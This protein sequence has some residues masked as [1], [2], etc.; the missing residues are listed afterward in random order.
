MRLFLKLLL[1]CYFLF[2]AAF[3]VLRYAILPNVDRYKSDI[4]YTISQAIG[5]NVSIAAINV[6]WQGLNPRLA[7][8]NVVIRDQQGQNALVLPN[9]NATVS[10]WSVAVADLRFEKIE[11]VKPALDIRRDVS[12]KLY[13]AGFLIEANQDNDSKGLE[14][15]LA[16]HEILIRDGQVRWSDQLRS[17]PELLLSEVNFVLNNRWRKHN[18]A[19]KATP[20]LSLA[21]PVDIRGSFQHP[22]FTRK[23]SDISS[24]TGDLYA[25]LRQADLSGLKA[26]ISYPADLQKG[27]GTVR[28][29]IRLE[30]GRVADLTAD[31]RLVDVLGQFRKDL[32]VL[33]MAQVSGRLIASEKLTLGK[34]YLPSLFGQSGHTI[35]L[36]DFAMQ[37]RDGI[38][39]PATTI[40]ES[41]FPGEKGQPERVELY[42]KL[43]N[44]NTLANFAEHLPLPADQRQMLL[45]FAPKGQ[46][47][48]FTAQ[49]Q[50]TYPDISAYS[51]KGQFIDLSMQPQA[52]QLA[53]PKVGSTP[54][55]AAIP[56]I[57]G[58][59][60][61]SGA[62]DASDKGGK[63]SLNSSDLSL[64]LPG[65]FVDPV[66]P[67]SA[68]Q[69]Q[70][71][72][73]F[74][75][76]DSLRFQVDKMEFQQAGMKGSLT[77]KHV[78]SMRKGQEEQKGEVDISGKLSGFDVK[79]IS[80][81]IP[82]NAPEDLRHWLTTALLDGRADDVQIRIKGDLAQ[83]PFSRTD[84]K[85]VAK[86]EFL[87][88]GKIV[89]GKLDFAPG[90]LADD[91]KSPLWPVI[92]N[93]RGNFIFDR[94]KME[95][96]GDTAKTLS[97][98]LYKVK[99]EIPD[100]L[101][102]DAILNID[103]KVSA[104]LQGMLQYVTASPVDGWLGHFL[105][106]TKA[107]ANAQ[108]A[109]KLQLPLKHL[110]ESKVQGVLQ[111]ANNDAV[112]QT[113][114]P[115]ISGINGKLEFNERGVNLNAL[116]GTLLGGAV[117]A[118]G[119]TQKDGS[120][121]IKL[122]GLA[123]AEGLRNV[124][125]GT[126]VEP[127]S[128]KI[129]GAARYNAQINVAKRQP[130]LIVDS[131]L[132]GLA[133]NFPSPLQKL[134]NQNLP[135]HFAMTPVVSGDASLLRDE[136]KLALGSVINAR[137]Q[138]QKSADRNAAWQV[139]RGGI[140]VNLPAP[141][142][143]SGLHANINFQTLN[144]DEWRRLVNVR[145]G[146]TGSAAGVSPQLDFSQYIEPSSLG[147]NTAELYFLDKKLDN[148]VLGA[149]HQKGMW[150]A[151]IDS[152][153]ASG[154]ISWNESSN[155]QGLG[156]VSARLSKLIIPQSAA[157]DVSDLLEG[158]NTSSQ[159]PGLDI[160]AEN[161]ELFNKKLGSLELLASNLPAA[162][163]R[164]WRINKLLLKNEDAQLKATG[165]WLS[166]AGD[167]VTHLNYVLDIANAGKLLDRLGFANI[168][169]GGR[170]KLEGDV[171]WNGLPFAL[172]IPSMNGQLQLELAVGQFL[173]VDP[174]AAKLLGVLSMQ[175]LARRLTLDF[176]DVFS[177]G[178]AFDG[179]NAT[180]QIQQGLARTD[181]FKM[182]SLNAT[183]LIDGS[184]DIAKETQDLHVAV[185]PEI[186]A[187][188][189][190]VV[191]A[192]AVNPVIGLGTFLAQLFLREPLA[193][194]FTYEYQVTGPWKDP[195]VAKFDNKEAKNQAPK[196]ESVQVK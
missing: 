13:V 186:N 104:G 17:A 7:F 145:T 86:G 182:R 67:F 5:R 73:K 64:Q 123:T 98:D 19:L 178:F 183:V 124:F 100:L 192:L 30:K 33:D 21:A 142:P 58:F 139:V 85:S 50:G 48:E 118:T 62:I 170:G 177:D 18:F 76:Q 181:N 77:G 82:S 152:R 138:R 55:R 109:L 101:S 83:F 80:R 132:Q 120:I 44:L 126:T 180:A 11:I 37:T 27:M 196:Q 146:A 190:S 111:F 161:F 25:D 156:N 95:I 43:L 179:I 187:G 38:S 9:V 91:G 75:A 174:G 24:W 166:G 8:G 23:V 78:L 129:V 79:E 45:A 168:V 74:E 53:R 133:L 119:G 171:R 1:V 134:S 149:S 29:W 10:W 39:L 28:S 106:E 107:T 103:G 136:I 6:S 56:A 63:F 61:L 114:I 14:W 40:R 2:S 49:W 172:D 60:H 113:G 160:V 189:A 157:G 105:Q 51:V 115:L 52:A 125:S 141:E 162:I 163:G 35:S 47:K 34:K 147:V 26:Y 159:I 70:A 164:E 3:L 191:Y 108:L 66:M 57:P 94:A 54:G 143:D 194:A 137:Y 185:I 110:V 88:K 32:P 93:I 92:D 59:D 102:H 128:G 36:I 46:L 193:R 148:V 144:V 165:K 117:V 131:S 87:I 72:W 16:Q 184:A 71:S 99:A 41:F 195:H 158:K 151:N 175:S 121:R 140:G 68:L 135:L 42:A 31:V 154:Y 153:Q 22:A 65:Y 173:K 84:G 176:R 167:G 15:V 4:E 155:G 169:R 81:F 69:M 12:G 112:L 127:L 97:N 96:N 90:H 130:E 188:T 20:P 122:D 89:D 116:K 150:Q